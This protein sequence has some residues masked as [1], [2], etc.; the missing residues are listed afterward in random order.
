MR[1][2]FWV[3]TK[4][5]KGPDGSDG[6]DFDSRG[7]GGKGQKEQRGDQIGSKCFFIPGRGSRRA[8]RA[9]ELPTMNKSSSK[10]LV[11]PGS[12]AISPAL[13]LSLTET[14]QSCIAIAGPGIWRTPLVL[15][16]SG[17]ITDITCLQLEYE[18]Y[19]GKTSLA[20]FQKLAAHYQSAALGEIRHACQTPPWCRVIFRRIVS[21]CRFD[22]PFDRWVFQV[23]GFIISADQFFGDSDSTPVLHGS[24]LIDNHV[25]RK[26]CP[27]RRNPNLTAL[28]ALGLAQ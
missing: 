12:S 23:S 9:V 14:A 13:I 27:I 15:S 3:P 2:I 22:I 17:E 20:A 16:P 1:V 8:G 24:L 19:D 5:G 21:R 25:S 6:F 10:G 28:A 11:R 4:K 7:E 26:Q 18:R